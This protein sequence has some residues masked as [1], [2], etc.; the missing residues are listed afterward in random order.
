M[1]PCSVFLP[2]HGMVLQFPARA[3]TLDTL[4]SVCAHIPP[5]PSTGPDIASVCPWQTLYTLSM[6]STYRTNTLSTPY[7][8]CVLATSS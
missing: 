4:Y 8:Y 1:V 7:V 6:Y 2:P 3:G 5:K